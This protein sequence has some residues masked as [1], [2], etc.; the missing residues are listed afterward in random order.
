MLHVVRDAQW[1]LSAGSQAPRSAR[2][3]VREQLETWGYPEH[4]VADV[5]LVT[6]ELVT[7]VLGRSKVSRLVVSLTAA[8]DEVRVTVGDGLL[9]SAELDGAALRIVTAIGHEC[10]DGMTPSGGTLWCTFTGW[11]SQGDEG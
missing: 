4:L 9:P 7:A 5:E 6:S 11:S 1:L 10:G 8:M 3:H 2:H